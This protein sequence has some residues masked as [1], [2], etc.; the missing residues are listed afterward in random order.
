V[1]FAGTDAYAGV[2]SD[3]S[4]TAKLRSI[5]TT[6]TISSAP[7]SIGWY[8][9]TETLSRTDKPGV[10]LV[11]QKIYLTIEYVNGSTGAE[12]RVK[13]SLQTLQNESYT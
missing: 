10:G 6:L 11:G 5:A 7:L 2:D 13:P 1:H 12:N 4:V 3:V 9:L 8:R